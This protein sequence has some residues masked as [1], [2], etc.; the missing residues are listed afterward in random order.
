MTAQAVERIVEEMTEIL[1]REA[2]PRKVVLFG[3]HARGAA[4]PASD[5]DF[6]VIEDKP[7]GPGRSRRREM[8]RLSRALARFP[9][10]QDILV[11]T[12]EEAEHW[13][14]SRNHVVARALREGRVLY[15]RA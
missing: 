9:V 3:S 12:A 5:L 15:E 6:L 14:S 11:Y 8:A 10:P 13:A 4:G 1:V 7:F 2:K